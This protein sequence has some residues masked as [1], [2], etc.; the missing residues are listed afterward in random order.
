MDRTGRRLTDVTG[1]PSLPRQ[2]QGAD[3][4]GPVLTGDTVEGRP[5]VGFACT[6]RTLPTAAGDQLVLG[7]EEHAGHPPRRSTDPADQPGLARTPRPYEQVD[8]AS[9]H[10]PEDLRPGLTGRFRELLHGPGSLPFAAPLIER[11]AASGHHSRLSGGAPRDLMAG[12]GTAGVNGVKRPLSAS[13]G[14][15]YRFLVVHLRSRP[16]RSART[17]ADRVPPA[18]LEVSL[19]ANERGTPAR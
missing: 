6:A 3:R 5:V 10:R 7:G 19:S 11:L 13:R 15:L 16:G 17:A 14:S 2:Q 9:T 4:A 1:T 18:E 12:A 8:P